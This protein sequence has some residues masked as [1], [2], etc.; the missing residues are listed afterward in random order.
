MSIVASPQDVS[1]GWIRMTRTR[2]I[3]GLITHIVIYLIVTKP[4]REAKA[5]LWA[6]APLMMM[7]MMMNRLWSF[8]LWNF[9]LPELNAFLSVKLCAL[10]AFVMSSYYER[11]ESGWGRKWTSN[12]A[13][14]NI[15]V[16]CRT[17]EVTENAINHGI[18]NGTTT[19]SGFFGSALDS[20]GS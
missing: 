1:G 13:S 6:L 14:L 19:Y 10:K 15:R 8:S 3:V 5:R 9:R 11:V 20:N 12:T 2:L 17:K 7:M 4:V 18:P 16:Q